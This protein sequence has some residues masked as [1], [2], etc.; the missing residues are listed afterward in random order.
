MVLLLHTTSVKLWLPVLKLLTALNSG[1][2]V[3]MYVLLGFMVSIVGHNL[4]NNSYQSTMLA[5]Q[6]INNFL[7]GSNI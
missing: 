2:Y 1:T 4:Y 5:P 3:C 6:S 7:R